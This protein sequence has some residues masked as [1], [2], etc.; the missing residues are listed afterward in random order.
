MQITNDKTGKTSSKRVVGIIAAAV[1]LGLSIYAVVAG[2]D[3]ANTLWTVAV[4]AG[5][6]LGLGVLE[7]NK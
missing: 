6:L 2:R 3:V 5:S 1:F 7:R 4:F